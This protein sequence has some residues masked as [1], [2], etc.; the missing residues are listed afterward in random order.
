MKSMNARE[1]IWSSSVIAKCWN[2]FERATPG[3]RIVVGAALRD[4]LGHAR[5]GLAALVRRS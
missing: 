5:E 3:G 1:T 4:A 2:A